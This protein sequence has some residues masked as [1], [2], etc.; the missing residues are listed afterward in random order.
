MGTDGCQC[1]NHMKSGAKEIAQCDGVDS[2]Y[3]SRMVNL[4][5]PAPEI[6]AAIVLHAGYSET[7][8]FLIVR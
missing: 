3:V 4:T 7:T 5:T 8:Q 6:V 2:S 1:Y